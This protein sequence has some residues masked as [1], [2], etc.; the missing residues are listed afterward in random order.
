MKS[1]FR[2]S[3]AIILLL[4]A[5]VTLVAKAGEPNPGE[6]KLVAQLP[7]ELPQRLSIGRLGK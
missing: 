1:P 7:P 6:L 5:Q 4:S 2:F 3:V